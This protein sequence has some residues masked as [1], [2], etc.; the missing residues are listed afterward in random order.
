MFCSTIP[1]AIMV[2]DV[3][4]TIA[5]A[6]ATVFPWSSGRYLKPFFVVMIAKSSSLL[7]AFLYSPLLQW[8]SPLSPLPMIGTQPVGPVP[9]PW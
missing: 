6:V 7:L 2:A 5:V 4:A 8:V 3:P 9:W 1:L